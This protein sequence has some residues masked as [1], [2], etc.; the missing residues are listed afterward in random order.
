MKVTSLPTS[1]GLPA[2]S[3]HR[4][5]PLP[6]FEHHPLTRLVVG[7]GTLERL[8]ELARELGGT[9]ILLV[10]DPGLEAA[11]QVVVSRAEIHI[12]EHLPPSIQTLDVRKPGQKPP[13][14]PSGPALEIALNLTFRANQIFVRGR[15]ID[16]ELGGT[17]RVTGTAT[18]PMPTGSFEMRRGQISVAGTT[19]RFTKGEVSFNGGSLADPSLD[20]TATSTASNIVATLHV[21][22]TASDPK[23][24]LSSTPELPQDEVL[25]HLLFGRSVDTLSPFQVA[26]I[27]LALAEL[28]GVAPGIGDPLEQVRQG[29]GLD[30]LTLGSGPGGNP[31]LQAGR[32]LAPGVFLGDRQGASS[33]STQGTIQF[34]LAKGLKLDAFVGTGQATNTYGAPP[35]ESQG[36]GVGLT[37]QFEY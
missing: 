31:S 23:I 24:T 35:T 12:P 13:P 17:V 22:G 36:S 8:G 5:A 37:Y 3:A 1:A 11:G 4:A 7:A 29:L 26:S 10:T 15:G 27:D 21:G 34:D 28:T 19:L 18:N 6:A 16:S 32:Y 2:P 14:P 30:V 20:F 33:N 9:R 25:A